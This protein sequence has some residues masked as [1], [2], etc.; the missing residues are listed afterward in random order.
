M[1][2]TSRLLTYGAC[3]LIVIATG[4]A[5]RGPRPVGG[6]TDA[7]HVGWVIMSGDAEN[8]DRDFVCKSNPREECAIPVDRPGARVL[9]DVHI[10]YHAPSTEM[11]FTGSIRIGFFDKGHELNRAVT[12]KPADSP[13]NQSVAGFVSSKP[14]TYTLTIAVDATST[15]TGQTQNIRDQVRVVVK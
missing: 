2:L 5:S 12:V 1:R 7:A 15:Q 3:V 11:K 6:P 9:S 8:P 10:Y 13:G 14:G 4:C